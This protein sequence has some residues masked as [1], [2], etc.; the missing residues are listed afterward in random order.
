MQKLIYLADPGLH[1]CILLVLL[2]FFQI[3][4]KHKI[5]IYLIAFS[6]FYAFFIFVSPVPYYLVLQLEKKAENLKNQH[7]SLLKTKKGLPS[8]YLGG[9]CLTEHRTQSQFFLQPCASRAINALFFA[10]KHHS[11]LFILSGYSAKSTNKVF[12]PEMESVKKMGQEL[13]LKSDWVIED[14]STNTYQNASFTKS[15]LTKKNI[16]NFFLITSATH[17][18]RAYTIFKNL[19]MKPIPVPVDH[20]ILHRSSPWTSYIGWQNH[21]L[22]LFWLYEFGAQIWYNFAYL[23]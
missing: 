2:V 15:I 4:Q 9:G 20:K 14:Q 11:P 1:L 8:V 19:G 10:K 22:W 18:P 7:W 12:H 6:A 3:Q 5:Q 16:H 23:R 21:Q 17:I 13:Q